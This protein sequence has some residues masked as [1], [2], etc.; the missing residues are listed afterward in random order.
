LQ[1]TSGFNFKTKN[2]IV[3][4]SVHPKTK[5]GSGFETSSFL[6]KK[7]GPNFDSGSENHTSGN[8]L[9]WNQWLTVD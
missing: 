9:N 1:R 4:V 5:S 7:F 6:H 2:R 8:C 3:L